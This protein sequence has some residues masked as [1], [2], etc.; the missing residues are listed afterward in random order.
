MTCESTYEYLRMCCHHKS[1]F[2]CFFVIIK[3][4]RTYI[5]QIFV[6]A[7][8]YDFLHKVRGRL[9]IFRRIFL[10]LA[11]S[12]KKATIF[13]MEKSVEKNIVQTN[14]NKPYIGSNLLL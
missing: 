13:Y 8:W 7:F 9:E 12:L 14:T 11:N 6:L 5:G 4:L 10:E 1:S 2:F 3:Y